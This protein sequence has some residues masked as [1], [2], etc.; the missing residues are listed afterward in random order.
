[1]CKRT[2]IS[3]LTLFFI[4]GCLWAQVSRG[5]KENEAV[6]LRD[7]AKR[8]ALIVGNSEY[9][10]A[11]VLNNPVNDADL[12]ESSL[13][14]AGFEVMKVINAKREDLEESLVDFTNR[15]EEGGYGV[16][17]YYYS[18]HGVEVKGTNYIIPVDARLDRAEQ[19]SYMCMNAQMVL[20][21]MRSSKV[22][23]KIM[24][25]DACRDNPLPNTARQSV[26]GKGLAGMQAP[27]GTFIGFATAMGEVALD[28]TGRYS[29]FTSALAESIL[30]PGLD[31]AHVFYRVT[32][33][34]Q[35]FAKRVGRSQT[36]YVSSS[37]NGSFVFTPAK[38]KKNIEND[39]NNK[40][41]ASDRDQDGIS[42]DLDDCP[43][44]FGTV[45]GCPDSDGD[46]ISD[47]KDIR[48]NDKGIKD[49]IGCPIF[50]DDAD[51]DGVK[52]E[53]DQCIL[54]KGKREWQGCPD[55]DGDRVPDHLDKCPTEPGKTDFHGCPEITT[56]SNYVEPLGGKFIFIKGGKY[57]MGCTSQDW[58]CGDNEM[59]AHFVTLDD[60]YLGET[61]VTYGQFKAFIDESGY[62]TDAEKIGT[63]NVYIDSKFIQKADVNWRFDAFG[64][65]RKRGDYDHPVVHVSWNDAVAYAEW[66][67]RKSGFT[68]RLPTEAEWEFAARGGQAASGLEFAGS[69]T[70]V[71][72]GWNGL[73]S[74]F[75][76]HN[77][78]GKKP[79]E[80]G[81]FDM[82]GNVWE[83]CEDWYSHYTADLAENPKGPTT[84]TA[85]VRRGGSWSGTSNNCRVSFRSYYVQDGSCAS[86]GFRLARSK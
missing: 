79:N 43:N 63:S 80:L 31:I 34:T 84:G 54:L 38:T 9:K 85:R 8:I 41:N 49:Q 37:L 19:V 24:I 45:N 65:K 12:M 21:M 55:S 61:E 40:T 72:I 83:L 26:G 51:G 57:K 50:A 77:V 66:L 14:K 59:L 58:D 86:L 10:H 67:S 20:D 18:G 76:S 25:L 35:E 52:N 60:F 1:M 75:N 42:D 4:Q 36:P 81:L 23:T 47:Q 13:R 44:E 71:E 68:Y 39:D 64:Q 33:S 30:I 70:V 3:I 27:D 2:S 82:S 69:N 29:P 28:G 48:P 15:V 73:N 53:I 46:G 6:L 62:V 32:A 7:P 22:T 16:A 17:L 78:K 5:I 11:D 74:G 56:K